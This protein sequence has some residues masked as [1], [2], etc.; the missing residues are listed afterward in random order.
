M[1]EQEIEKKERRYSD[2][3][4]INVC[5]SV[6]CDE[7]KA[8]VILD[9]IERQ[10]GFSKH[11]GLKEGKSFCI[12]IIEGMLK[13]NSICQKCGEDIIQEIEYGSKI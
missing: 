5:N 2:D 9:E 7:D 13:D 8:E 6:G 4:Y 12:N 11:E 1:E 10:K 3:D